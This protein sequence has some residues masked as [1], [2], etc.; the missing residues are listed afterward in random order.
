MINNIIKDQPRTSGRLR[1]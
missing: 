1:Q